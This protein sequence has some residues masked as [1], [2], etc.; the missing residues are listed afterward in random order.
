VPVAALIMVGSTPT[1]LKLDVPEPVQASALEKACHDGDLD[2]VAELE[3]Q[4]WFGGAEREPPQVNQ[5][6]R[7]LG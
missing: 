5:T 3:T 1:G 7:R 6:M 4:I 2:P